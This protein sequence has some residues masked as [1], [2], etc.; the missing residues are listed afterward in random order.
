[1][2]GFLATLFV[3]CAVIGGIWFAYEPYIKPFIESRSGKSMSADDAILT[4]SS[5]GGGEGGAGSSAAK[6]KGSTGTPS[7]GGS[8]KQPKAKSPPA[9][10]KSAKAGPAKTELDLL[11]E[12]KYPLPEIRPLLEIVNNWT[13]VP[14]NAFPGEVAASEEIR[15]E[16][17]INGQVAGSSSVAPGTPLKPVRLVGDQLT[18]ANLANPGQNTSIAVDKTDFKQR[19]EQR[20]D[21]FVEKTTGNILA[22]RAQVKKVIEANPAKMALLTGETPPATA[23]SDAGDPRFSPVKDSL[24]KGEVA[25]VTLEEAESYTWNGSEKVGGEYAGTYETVTVHFEVATIFGRFPVNYKC[26]LRGGRVVA[27]IDPIT[28]DRV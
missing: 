6:A 24:R 16:L 3:V 28:E 12:E 8:G 18:I 15:F 25:S 26:L 14:P 7:A 1:M 2:K 10:A 21:E 4:D 27:W 22:R 5:P 13:S 23:A 20:Y 17:V 19:I 11:L 9:S